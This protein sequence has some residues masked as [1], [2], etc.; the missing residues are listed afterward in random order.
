M[1]YDYVARDGSGRSAHIMGMADT[2]DRVGSTCLQPRSGGRDFSSIGC[3]D[4][5]EIWSFRLQIVHPDD[6]PFLGDDQVRFTA[7]GS[8]AVFDPVTTRDPS[9][10]GRLIYT[11]QYRNGPSA[12]NPLSPLARFRGCERESYVEATWNNSNGRPIVY[13]TDAY[14]RVNAA[15]EAPG[16]IR[17]EVSVAPKSKIDVFKYRRD[18]CDDT[19][20]APN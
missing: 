14:G 17:Q 20:R 6:P 19:V 7:T 11:E 10:S 16:L 15:G 1:M 9:D 13:W 12:S 3:F 8:V 4:P 2:S 5:Y 18:F